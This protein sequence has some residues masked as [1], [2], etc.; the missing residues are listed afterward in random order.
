MK[1][2]LWTMAGALVLAALPLDAQ[3]VSGRVVEHGTGRGVAFATVTV[4]DGAGQ[5]AGYAQTDALGDYSVR[6][7]A[8]GQYFVRAEHLAYQPRTSGLTNVREGR[9]A[10]RNLA[11][12]PGNQQQLGHDAERGLLPRG[13]VLPPPYPGLP[14][15]TGVGPATN[16]APGG[17]AAGERSVPR[18]AAPAD[19]PRGEGRDARRPRPSGE[20]GARRGDPQPSTRQP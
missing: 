5:A 6:V 18:T 9:N 12:R 4:L 8:A 16:T 19:R 13:T 2:S 17:D 20:R 11:L 10:H 14:P 1:T 15:V 3:S 7:R